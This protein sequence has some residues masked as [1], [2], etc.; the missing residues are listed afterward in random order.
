MAPGSKTRYF[1]YPLP[2]EIEATAEETKYQNPPANNPVF[3]GLPLQILSSVV[4]NLGFVQQLFWS[5]A[6]FGEFKKLKGLGDVDPCFNP[7][8]VPVEGDDAAADELSPVDVLIDTAFYTSS[9]F[10]KL[11]SDREV[12]VTQVIQ[13]LLEV[14]A[15]PPHKAAINQV[16]PDLALAAADAS[17]KRYATGRTL[18]P[19][20]GVPIVVKDELYVHGYDTT[21]GTAKV[22][23]K[24]ESDT[25][26]CV[27]KLEEAGA[28]LIAKSCMHELGS[29][30]T[31]CNPVGGHTPRNPYN[32]KYYCGGSSG[33][34]AYCV[35]AGIVPIAVGCDGG[36]SIRIPSNYCGIYGLKPSHGRVSS[37]PTPGLS[38]G[39]GVTGPMCATL[40]DVKIAYRI[41]AVPDP[42]TVV[43]AMFPM[44]RDPL[45]PM[46]A[47]RKKT[48]GIYKQWFD[49]C[50]PAVHKHVLAAVEGLEKQGYEIVSLPPIP[51]LSLARRV[52]SLSIITD[53][54]TFLSGNYTGLSPANRSLFSIAAKTPAVDLIAV[55]KIRTMMMSHFAALWQKY[56]GMIV[57]TP[58]TPEVGAKI[59]E[60]H[61]KCGVIDGDS[62]IKSMK[63]VSVGNLMGTPGINSV[64]GYDDATNLPVSLLGTAE[65]GKEEDLLGWAAEVAKASGF[66]RKKPE[67][68]V[69]VLSFDK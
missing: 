3:S 17:S 5:N 66:V 28:I 1:N 49:D 8:V 36:G 14:I 44:L 60:A 24:G 52:H 50:S 25:A 43:S 56:P 62:S 68:W 64:V 26:W 4:S 29:D 15:Q 23:D 54:T 31:N 27:R 55:N 20:D 35:S 13:K 16:L 12:T 32:S 57:V 59:N 42:D 10:V 53:M 63:Y 11:Y 51:H 61:L 46:T 9:D 48:I 47:Q 45:A 67:N 21:F 22:F 34:S 30:T 18:G 39:N 69:D 37:R 41:M 2:K 65:W 33:G 40:E 58:A 7:Y 38:P 6:G 19:L